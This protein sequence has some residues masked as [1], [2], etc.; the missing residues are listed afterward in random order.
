VDERIIAKKLEILTRRAVL[1]SQP[2]EGW[3][4][5]L[6]TY[7]APGEYE[8]EGDWAPLAPRATFPA[9]RATFPALKTVLL[10]ASVQCPSPAA[11]A[12]RV[13]LR[14][15]GEGLEGL[16]SVDGRPYA[17]L[18]RNH[19]RV[20]A[21]EPGQHALEIEAMSV[22]RAY[23]QPELRDTR[24][25][26]DGGALVEVD[27][28]IEAAC[29]D[30]QFAWEA[31]HAIQDER[32][33]KRLAAALE[34]SLLQIDLT[35]AQDA[36]RRDVERARSILAEGISDIAPDPEGGCVYLVGHTHIDTAWLW[37]LSETVRKCGRTFATAVRLMETYPDFHFSCSQAQLYAYTRE[38]FPALYQEIGTWVAR[39]RWH[40]TGAMWVESDCNVPSG[41]SLIR[42]FLHG[43]A[44]YRREFGTRPRTCWLPDVFGYPGSLPQIL[45]GCG[46]PYFMTCKLHWQSSNPFPDH[47][48]WWEGVDGSRVLAH[49]PKLRNYYNG[50]P[51]PEQLTI[52]WNSF[53][54]KG[55]YDE[56]M[57]PFGYGDG[58][59]GVTPEM[60]EFVARAGSFPGLP[61][62]RLG[63]EEDYFDRALEAG[64][65]LP[66]WVGEL[67]LETHRGTYTSQ[68]RT[69]QANRISERALREAEIWASIAQIKGAQVSLSPLQEAWQRVLT[70]QFHDI[71][72]GSSIGE[73]YEDAQADHEW[74]QRAAAGVRDAALHWLAS[75]EGAAGDL[76][77]F[78][79]LSWPRSDPVEATVADPGEPFHLVDADANPIPV[80]VLGSEGGQ[81]R[82]LFEP[83]FVPAMGRACF[84][85]EKGS[86]DLSAPAAWEQGLEN[87]YFRVELDQEGAIVCL[88]D[89]R[90][91]REVVPEGERANV[92]QLFQDGPEREAAWNVHDTFE[93]RQYEMTEPARITVLER[94]PVRA[95][96]RVERTY[97]KT[98]IRLDIM[99]YR[100][101]PRIDFVADVDWQERQ[102]MLKVA[103]PV[104]VRSPQASYEIQFGAIQRPT[105]R[106]TSWEQ[107]K[108]EVAAQRWADLSEAG[109]GVSLLNDS[110]YGYDVRGNVLRLT[111]LRGPEY[112]DP[113]ADLGRH[114]FAYA[115]F[116]HPGDWGE[117]GTV[118]CARELNEPMVAVAPVGEASGKLTTRSYLQVEGQAA[119]VETLKPAEDGDGWILRLYE[120]H[121]GRGAVR[122]SFDRPLAR[123]AACNLVEE[124]GQ[125]VEVAD[126]GLNLAVRPFEIKTY[127]VAFAV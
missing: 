5:R 73:V 8:Y 41:E 33:R 67:Y 77:V 76:C 35:V 29:Y 118:R 98:Q 99:L 120:P 63:G 85:L 11:P 23:C 42:Q 13:D 108:F 4:V 81:L 84:R 122:V 6:A 125:E 37:P 106:N 7:H 74:A 45:H 103:F 17:G 14:L 127:R 126:G 69:K 38:H 12:G 78:N 22:L 60:M 87:E 97:R 101:T 44:F 117:G 107:Q 2:I 34:A 115:L 55:I 46:I 20:P 32:R 57:L 28:E 39:G 19:S 114:A 104:T 59:G 64:Q 15:D 16:V 123:A 49:I 72:P 112:P 68:S 21:P 71:L 105:H 116:P 91:G 58:G 80:Q 10:K 62:T 110:R 25:T 113:R 30:I 111:L 1:R 61:A 56:V 31:T 79:A 93:K 52:A 109:Y 94:G 124:E 24:A 50:Y 102:T 90:C 88:L 75:E 82:I 83:H 40:T 48:F 36:L 92:W 9:P 54:Q 70:Q 26:F 119:I 100:Q 27:R 65:E 18:D 47:L 86:L 96:V 66:V 95:A 89:K 51:N 43:L 53:L 3:Q 121:G